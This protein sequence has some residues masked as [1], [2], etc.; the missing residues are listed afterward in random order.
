MQNFIRKVLGLSKKLFISISLFFPTH[1][2]LIQ[3]SCNYFLPTFLPL[4]LPSWASSNSCLLLP[5][6]L[7][8]I[9]FPKINLQ[10]FTT[11]HGERGGRVDMAAITFPLQSGPSFP[12]SI[13]RSLSFHFLFCPRH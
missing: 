8:S 11:R 10:I 12:T 13:D 3:F 7:S 4:P 9:S 1:S 5:F 2:Q 6:S